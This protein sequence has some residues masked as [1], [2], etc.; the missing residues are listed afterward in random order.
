MTLSRYLTAFIVTLFPLAASANDDPIGTFDPLFMS[1]D[2]LAIEIE[3]PFDEITRERSDELELPGMLRYTATDGS[4]VEL[5]VQLRAR[6][7]RRR[8]P[9]TCRF[10]PV[11]INFKKSQTDNTLFHKQDK[12]K[13]V[14]HCQHNNSYKQTVISEYLVYRIFNVLTDYSFRARLLEVRYVYTDD[15]EVTDSY[16]IFIEHNDRIGKRIG[17]EPIETE[18]VDVATIKPEDLNLTSVFHYFIGN[19]DFSP[20]AAPPDARC[21]HNQTLFTHEDGLYRTVPYDFDQ[22]GL[23]GAKH[24]SP[25]ERFNLRSVRQR[26]Y[27]GRCVNNDQ[28]PQTLQLFRDK[29]AEIE[30][31]IAAQPELTD[32]RRRGMLKY[33]DAFYDTIDKPKRVASNLIKRCI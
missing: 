24:A 3:G 4:V 12:I 14:T 21:C 15:D 7:N 19:T 29:R 6:G 2:T 22:S 5:D 18:R 10:P 17:G 9:G 27:R 31:L 26:L 1:T 33:I 32:G 8:D 30:A 20:R 16:G 25:N 23:V 11:R 28:L 13:L